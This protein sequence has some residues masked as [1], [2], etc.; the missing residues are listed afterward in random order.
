MTNH[1]PIGKSLS[2]NARAKPSSP[3]NSG[4][5]ESGDTAEV[6]LIKGEPSSTRLPGNSRLARPGLQQRNQI[7]FAFFPPDKGV[8]IGAHGSFSGEHPRSH[9]PSYGAL[10]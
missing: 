5:L 4:Q 3:S 6:L 10:R 2:R 7:E 9:R 8:N 1:T